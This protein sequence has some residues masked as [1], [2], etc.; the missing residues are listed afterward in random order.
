MSSA[1]KSLSSRLKSGEA[2]VTSWVM[3]PSAAVAEQLGRA[4][5]P[6]VTL[7]LQ[8]GQMGMGEAREGLAALALTP[9]HAIVRMGVADLSNAPRFLDMGAEAVIAPM[10]ETAADAQA[11]ADVVKYP[12][13]GSRSWGPL[14]AAQLHGKTPA[15]YLARANGD[16]LALAMIETRTA[17]AQVDEILAV[18]G[19]DGVFVG[20]SDLSLAL[21]EGAELNPQSEET[22]AASRVIA[23]AARR[24][25]KVAG[26]F[27]MSAQEVKDAKALGYTLMAL[28]IDMVL[29]ANAAQAVLAA[30]A[31]EPKPSA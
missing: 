8:H 22:R 12:P 15:D 29:L 9:A 5:Y 30:C 20:P 4:G 16:T 31:D 25:G 28:G 1:Q 6:A 3:L 24:A 2:L 23:D 26:I 21:S 19:I 27:C 10:I 14:R 18:P 13:L 7:D 11:F 17:L